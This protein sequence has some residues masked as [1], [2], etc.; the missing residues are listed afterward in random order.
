M[1]LP[2][3]AELEFPSIVI[4]GYTTD[5]RYYDDPK[6]RK[7]RELLRKVSS[8]D[9]KIVSLHNNLD[10]TRFVSGSKLKIKGDLHIFGDYELCFDTQNMIHI[11]VE[12]D[13]YLY[14][15]TDQ[16]LISNH[17]DIG[18]HYPFEVSGD[19][20]IY[21]SK[22]VFENMNIDFESTEEYISFLTYLFKVKKQVN[23]K[24]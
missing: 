1:F 9:K 4:G 15:I 5:W 17:T 2:S 24:K 11:D 12:G 8:E 3:T 18:R 22:L 21:G 16:I 14:A 6:H 10:I 19:L 20:N 13:L 7:T 23:F